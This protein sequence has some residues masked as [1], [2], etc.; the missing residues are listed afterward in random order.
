[1]SDQVKITF[2]KPT[3]SVPDVV[4]CMGISPVTLC[5]NPGNGVPPYTYHWSNGATTQCISVSDTLLYTVTITDSKGCQATG[6]GRFHARDCIGQL[7]HTS[8]TCG[9][10]EGGTA[11]DFSTADVSYH[12][13]GN[14]IIT[15]IAPGV[16]FY[17]SKVTAPAA[18]FTIN[19]AETKSNAS[20]PFIPI[21]Q[22]NQVSLYDADCNSVTGGTETTPGQGQIVVHGAVPGQVFIL[23][24]KY[25]LKDLVGAYL[26][27]NVG[28]HFDFR[29]WINGVLV[30][31][32]PDGLTLGNASVVGVGPGSR[33][34]RL[35]HPMP[36]P[37]TGMTQMAYSVTKD[38][39]RVSIKVYDVAGRMV[40]ALVDGS[41]AAGVYSVSWNGK[42]EQGTTLRPGMYFVQVRIGS[43]EQRV[44]VT[45]LK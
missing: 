10:F 24:V 18:D 36:N 6:S 8:A 4:T 11:Q 29:T 5:A 42:D 3:V 37:F 1:V 13:D 28:C 34:V 15:T 30:D 35:F 19:I 33:Y 45:F 12:V 25:S 31:A 22:G 39:D 16:F 20:F 27:P 2:D 23:S 17:W 7:T 14:N 40:K 32:D 43:E 26:D 9:S 21:Q 38:Q 44:R 41:Q